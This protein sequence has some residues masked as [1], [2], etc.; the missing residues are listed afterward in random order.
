MVVTRRKSQ[1]GKALVR[2]THRMNGYIRPITRV[3]SVAGKTL[4]SRK[5]SG[6]KVAKRRKSTKKK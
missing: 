1:S 2:C 3:C 6:R 4:G 5:K